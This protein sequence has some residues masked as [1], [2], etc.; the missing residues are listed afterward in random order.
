M[1]SD[2]EEILDVSKQGYP[3]FSSPMEAVVALDISAT[4]HEQKKARDTRGPE[5]VFNID[6][7]SI[8][9]LAEC[10]R[11]EQRIPLTDE[12]LAVCAAAGIT[13]IRG[14][15]IRDAAS[16]SD[17]PVRFPAV[18]KLLSRDAS[19][20]S[21]IGGVKVNIRT[22]KALIKAV[23][24]MEKTVSSLQAAPVIDGFLVQEMAPSGIECFVGARRDPVFGP[25]VMV[26]LGGVFV[27][28]FK[29]RAIRLAPVTES[30]A[31]SMLK[32]LKAYPLLTGARGNKQSDTA[33]LIE[34]VCRVSGLLHACSEIGELDLNPVIVH[35]EGEGVSVVDARVFFTR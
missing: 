14:Q 28:I 9:S 10:C 16:A 11:K 20:K 8:Q 13:P 1:I 21:D 5:A 34:I 30:E 27:E 26:G 31:W 17:V 12:A 24:E 29:D 19:H 32:E 7:G 33:A 15:M 18:V 3:I 2:R 25:L 4:Y 6:T 23:S 22:R 35:P